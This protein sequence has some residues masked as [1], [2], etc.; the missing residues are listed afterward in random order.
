MTQFSINLR[1]A[2]KLYGYSQQYAAKKIGC[3]LTTYQHWEYN[4]SSPD[5]KYLVRIVDAF[6]ITD[7]RKFISGEDFLEVK[8]AMIEEAEVLVKYNGLNYRDK[9]IVNQLMGIEI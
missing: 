7:V 9:R 2:R 1:K 8:N 5:I 6:N 4:K 3:N